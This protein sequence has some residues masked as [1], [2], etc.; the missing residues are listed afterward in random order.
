MAELHVHCCIRT[1]TKSFSQT[2]NP[3]SLISV[4]YLST[5]F[6]FGMWGYCV[7][8]ASL[9]T[10]WVHVIF[11]LKFGFYSVIKT[12]SGGSLGRR[13]RGIWLTLPCHNPLQRAV[14]VGT[15]ESGSLEAGTKADTNGECCS[16]A[17]LSTAHSAFLYNPGPLLKTGVASLAIF[18]G[19]GFLWTE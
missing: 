1:T 7:A 10:P 11:C 8:Q 6:L 4:F 9:L 17:L 12:M 14:M 3:I 15:W 16:L 19:K 5:Y 13:K 2:N 18:R